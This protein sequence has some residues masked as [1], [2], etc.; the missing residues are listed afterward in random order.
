MLHFAGNV[1][2]PVTSVTLPADA[3]AGYVS[4]VGS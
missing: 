2:Q 4:E 3:S 1:I